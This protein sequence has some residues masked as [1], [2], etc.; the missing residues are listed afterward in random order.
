[1]LEVPIKRVV[2]RLG[3][4]DN[5]NCHVGAL[6]FVTFLGALLSTLPPCA[7]VL[8]AGRQVGT[9]QSMLSLAEAPPIFDNEQLQLEE[10]NA[11]V[12][13]IF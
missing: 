13:Y 9:E 12:V 8:A 6:A 3:I 4:V 7:I 5:L 1:M 2:Q 10:R 11:H